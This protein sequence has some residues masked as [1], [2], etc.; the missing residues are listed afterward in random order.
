MSNADIQKGL[1]EIVEE[2]AGVEAA[3][4]TA[5]KSFVDDLDIDSL[6]M[7]EIAVQAEDKFGV[8]IPDDELAN[9]KTVGDAV[10]YIAA[11]A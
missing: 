10:N 2:V 6:S 7:V 4:V 9:L 8:K 1:A 5:D 11:N 3:D